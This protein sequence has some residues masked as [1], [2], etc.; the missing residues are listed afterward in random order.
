VRPCLVGILNITP[1]SFYDG[2]AH[3]SLDHAIEH[4]FRLIEEGADVIDIGGEST[5]PGAHVVS[6]EEECARVID[7]VKALSPHIPISI[8]TTKPLVAKKALL[9]GATI[10]NDVQGLQNPELM[11]LSANFAEVVIMHS[12]GT[13]K[14]MR[15]LSRYDDIGSQLH[16]FFTQQIK[17]C[18]CPKIWLD[19]G[20]GF[21]KTYKQSIFL[22]N[23]VSLFSDLGHPLYIGASRKSF[24]PKTLEISANVDRLP[25]SLAA[26]ATT[27]LQG[28]KAF[29][30]HDVAQTK[31][32]LDML[33]A[34]EDAQ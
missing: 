1:D 27:Y 7:V 26:V 31:Q 22:L 19:P 5:R 15:T 4:A 25:G 11:E 8:D 10:L 17:E 20:I 3:R 9:A 6:V 28:A 14:T 33:I 2:G 34:I 30:V 18:R 23:N 12:R 16:A 13:P 21:A 24:I 32:F 29:R